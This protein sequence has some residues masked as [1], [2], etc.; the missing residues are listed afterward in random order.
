MKFFATKSGI[1]LSGLIVGFF[2]VLL[3]VLGNPGNMGVCIACFYRDMAGAMGMHQAAV[4]QYMRPEV[5]GILLGAFIIALLTGEFKPQG[6]SS[7][8]VRFFLGM[9][10]MFGALV[11]LGCPLRMFLRLGA[12]DLNALV[13]L[14]GF[15][16][17]ILTGIAFLKKGFTLGRAYQQKSAS[18]L[19][20]PF[21]FLVLLILAGT[22]GLFVMSKEGPGSMHAPFLVSLVVG[23]VVGGIAQ[24]TRLCIAGG[25]RDAFLIKDYHLTLGVLGLLAATVV[26]NL[27]FGKFKLS[28]AEQPIAHSMHLWNFLG[29]YVVGLG[30]VFLG[31]CPLRQTVLAGQ[32]NSDSAVTI[33]GFIVGAAFAHNFGIAASPKGV[34]A[35]GQIVVLVS[36]VLLVVIGILQS[37]FSSACASSKD[38]VSVKG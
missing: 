26:M 18:G 3:V 32:G 25:I 1:I 20:L 38:Q 24:R 27:I 22:T 16:G 8:V 29:L 23:L 7:T 10:V 17:G 15:I 28:F 9:M 37:N 11:F 12:G 21:V 14:F 36:I 19:A 30:S 35:A 4:V 6:G 13:A 5:M 33:L 31:G 34:P 2:G